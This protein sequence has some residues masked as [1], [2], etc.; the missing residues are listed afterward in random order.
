MAHRWDSEVQDVRLVERVP[1]RPDPR[2]RAVT[3]L[4]EGARFSVIGLPKDLTT[5]AYH[6]DERELLGLRIFYRRQ[7]R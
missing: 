5:L 2:P 3:L 1:G 7:R 6:H 4:R